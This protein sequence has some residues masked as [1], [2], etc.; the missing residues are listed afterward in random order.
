[1]IAERVGRDWMS[2]PGVL[3]MTCSLYVPGQTKTLSP[4][5][6][7]STAAW[8]VW[9]LAVSQA[10]GPSPFL[11]SLS[12]HLT[13]TAADVGAANAPNTSR[14]RESATPRRARTDRTI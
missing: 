13:W 4:G 5:C 11:L 7:A 14:L 12:T 6:E 10:A 2:S 3:T 9:K 8:I 1:M